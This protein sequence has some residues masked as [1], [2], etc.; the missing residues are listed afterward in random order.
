VGIVGFGNIGRQVARRLS[1]FGCGLIYHDILELSTGRE[2]ELGAS[3][4][5]R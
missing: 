2:D 3:S 4:H 1:G 5:G